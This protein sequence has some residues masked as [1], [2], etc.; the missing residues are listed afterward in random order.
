MPSELVSI[1]ITITVLLVAVVFFAIGK[2]RSDIVALCAL[3]CLLLTGVLTPAEALSGFSNNIILTIAGM[4]IVGGAI[5]RTGLANM[6]S[7]RILSVAGTN[8]NMLFMVFMLIT[9]LVGSLVSSTGTV[10]IMMPIVVSLATSINVSPSRFLMPLAFMASIGG[11]L[12]LIGNPPNMVVNDV[13][14]KAG[15]ESLTLFSYL[16]VGMVCLF[17]GLFILAPATSAFLARRKHDT[18]STKS[19]GAALFEL[20]EQYD[21]SQNS[22]IVSVPHNSPMVGKSLLELGLPDRFGIAVQ[23]IR[24]TAKN[25]SSLFTS[26]KE[27][28]IPPSART[29]IQSGDTIYCQGASERITDFAGEMKVR[30]QG[31]LK[32]ENG[33]GKY[34]FDSVG[35]C[36]LVIMSAATIV[37]R[38]IADSG[39][40]EQYGIN[41]LGIH[42][43]NQYIL[44]DLRNQVI[45]SGDA[46]LVQGTW[47]DLT[48][49]D[50]KTRH[51]VVVG[52]PQEHA[53]ATTRS[54]KM[55]LVA[56]TVFLMIGCMATGLLPT[57][58]AVLAG[59]MVLILGGCF[60]NIEGAY[61]SINWETIVM[62]AAM[63]PM[64]IAM[65]KTGLVGMASE[66]ITQLGRDYGPTAAFAVV[67]GITS[68]MNIIISQTP[69]S[70]LVAP[71]A[72][73]IAVDLGCSPLPFLFGVATS[74]CMCFAS[75]F[76]T[77]S[78]AL[79]MSAGRYTFFD[80]LKIGLPLQV[81]MGV[82]MVIALPLLFP[83]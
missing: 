24:R 9:A 61:S 51:W 46:I 59:A 44:D 39:L 13:Y 34:R 19:R 48:R 7:D 56:A 58:T 8:Q 30:V 26:S 57:V 23:E 37:G 75:P 64:A 21:L 63:L 15:F 79:V 31:T 42:R 62:I 6:I 3:L 5:V 69:V 12:T 10:A 17:F 32:K 20:I 71:V 54:E 38:T 82:V 18:V 2:L 81:L 73:Q 41:V 27:E 80:Y 53:A 65:E 36:E 74:A 50:D 66:V 11:M 83:F 72:I 45:Q 55:P 35:L 60:R 43:R 25:G 33:R 22:Y 70:L 76:S 29:V 16:P 40:R 77:P 14:V 52:R 1:G 67:Y 47:A 28:Q 4:F 49:L 68:V 78:N